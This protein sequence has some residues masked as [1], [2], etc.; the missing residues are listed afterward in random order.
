MFKRNDSSFPGCT[1]KQKSDK[2]NVFCRLVMCGTVYCNRSCLSACLSVTTS[3]SL[4]ETRRF[5]VSWTCL[6]IVCDT[7][8]QT[9]DCQSVPRYIVHFKVD[10]SPLCDLNDSFST[11]ACLSGEE[12]CGVPY[13]DL[14]N[15]SISLIACRR[16]SSTVI[17]ASYPQSTSDIVMSDVTVCPVSHW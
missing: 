16:Q 2:V 9:T 15:G 1:R 14:A 10:T 6:L 17:M 7:G 11:H 3:L 4:S 13:C 8:I 12:S 5:T